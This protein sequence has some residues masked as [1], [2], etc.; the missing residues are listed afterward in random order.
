MLM[1][2]LFRGSDLLFR[3]TRARR[4]SWQELIPVASTF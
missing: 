3:L 1:I 4:A 2:G